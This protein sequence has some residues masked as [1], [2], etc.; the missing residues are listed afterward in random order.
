MLLADELTKDGHQVTIISSSFFHQRKSFRSKKS[1]IIKV[2]K[3]LKI[4]LINSS[5]YKK[6]ISL[7]R[8]YDHINLAFNL[9]KFLKKNKGFRPDKIFVGYPPIETSYVI[10]NWA[11]KIISL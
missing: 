3:N 9:H 2:K 1:K 6:N 8:I 4:I 11:K 7:R 10:I 5:G